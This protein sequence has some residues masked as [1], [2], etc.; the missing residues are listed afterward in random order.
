MDLLWLAFLPDLNPHGDHDAS[1]HH[2]NHRG[3]NSLQETVKKPTSFP[4]GH[5]MPSPLFEFSHEHFC[6]QKL[7]GKNVRWNFFPKL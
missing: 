2:D 5:V 4:I 1:C 6:Q 3:N 7:A